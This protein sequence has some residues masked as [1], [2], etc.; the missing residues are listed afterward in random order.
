MSNPSK[1]FD[2]SLASTILKQF[3]TDFCPDPDLIQPLAE[4]KWVIGVKK[5]Q[6]H[7]LRDG[8]IATDCWLIIS[9]VVEITSDG[10]F[11]TER[12][13]GEFLGEQAYLEH[14]IGKPSRTV[15]RAEIRATGEEVVFWTIDPSFDALLSKPEH[16]AAR[17]VWHQTLTAVLNAKL[18]EAIV[19][20]AKL[21]AVIQGKDD[22]LNRFA[23]GAALDLVRTAAY[24]GRNQVRERD[25]IIWFSDIANFSKWSEQHKE[26]PNEVAK[27]AR[28]LTEL[29]IDKI[30]EAGGL[31]DKIQ[32]DGLMAIW[33]VE[34][35]W[36]KTVPRMAV[37]CAREIVKQ[38]TTEIGNIERAEI[39][40]I[41]IGMHWGTVAFG[42]FGTAGRI[43]VTVL[44]EPVNLASRYES[45]KREGGPPLG[46]IRVSPELK[47]LIDGCEGPPIEFREPEKVEVKNGL[48]IEIYCVA[49]DS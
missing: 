8:E 44:G 30:R 26:N 33:F 38:I 11:V 9:G 18:G 29:Q 32:G 39:L 49:E 15:P 28:R 7:L 21:R 46:R 19:D 36:K 13:A 48:Q 4:A 3:L 22:W 17:E 20:R 35:R 16:R 6:S 40:D 10:H 5:G 23:D 1:T 25:V 2:P 43:A 24:G 45:A 12:K 27:T 31:I 41:R 14:V 42:D 47:T 34:G 37:G